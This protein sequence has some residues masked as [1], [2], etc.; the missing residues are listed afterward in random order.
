M[1]QGRLL[2][3]MAARYRV[4]MHAASLRVKQ[5]VGLVFRNLAIIIKTYISDLDP[6]SVKTNRDTYNKNPSCMYQK[7]CGSIGVGNGML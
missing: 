5:S 2:A 6:P 3:D 4:L 1:Y 7:K